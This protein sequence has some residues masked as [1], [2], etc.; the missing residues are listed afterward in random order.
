MS[1]NILFLPNCYTSHLHVLLDLLV[2]LLCSKE[3]SLREGFS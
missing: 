1:D 2:I 3:L